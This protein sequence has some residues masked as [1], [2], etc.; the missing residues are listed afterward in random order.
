MLFSSFNKK[1]LFCE[2]RSKIYVINYSC[3]ELMR[4]QLI[5]R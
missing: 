3:V 1:G 2:P 5:L 4:K